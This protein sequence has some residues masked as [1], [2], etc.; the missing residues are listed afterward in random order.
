[1]SRLLAKPWGAELLADN[2]NHIFKR[3]EPRRLLLRSVQDE[4]R[5]VLSDMYRRLDSR[6]IL[7]AFAGA[8]REIGVVPVEG[9]GGDLRFCLRAVLPVARV[10]MCLPAARL[11]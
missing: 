11:R 5:G 10:P 9:V 8:C 2:L 3:E 4:V 6:P 7:D 1:V